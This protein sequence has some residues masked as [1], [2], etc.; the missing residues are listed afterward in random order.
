[1]T[2]VINPWSER[3]RRLSKRHIVEKMTST[4]EPYDLKGDESGEHLK[5]EFIKR[6]KRLFVPTDQL[7]GLVM[8]VVDIARAHSETTYTDVKSYISGWGG[9]YPGGL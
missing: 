2:H 8:K 6:Y 3:F 7:V 1:M 5:R 4:P 9:L